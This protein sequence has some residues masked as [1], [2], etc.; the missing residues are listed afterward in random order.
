MSDSENQPEKEA[1]VEKKIIGTRKVLFMLFLSVN[2]I[3][4][5]V[6][7][8]RSP[9]GRPCR[10]QFL[11]WACSG[12]DLKIITI[13]KDRWVYCNIIFNW[14]YANNALVSRT[15]IFLFSVDGVLLWS[16]CSAV[17]SRLVEK[18]RDTEIFLAVSAKFIG[19]SDRTDKSAI[20]PICTLSS[21]TGLSDVGS[22]TMYAPQDFRR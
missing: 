22:G 21:R 17:T 15:C 18:P 20:G 6:M 5:F 7:S 4:F 13:R 3:F 16:K 14:I 8:S 2:Q 10:F 1:E 9:R 11:V 19:P 12:F